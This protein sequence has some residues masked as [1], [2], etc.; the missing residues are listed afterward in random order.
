M[1][2][3]T[4]MNDIRIG[5]GYDF[6]KLIEGDS[7][8]LAGVEIKCK[9]EIS[10]HSDGDIVLHALSDSIYGAIANGDI[11]VHF[12]SNDQNLDISS[13]HILAHACETLVTSGYYIGN[14]D[15][16]I[17]LEEPRIQDIVPEMRKNISNLTSLNMEYISIKSSTSQGVGLIGNNQA[18]ACYSSI[19]IKK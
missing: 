5:Y 19:L 17:L 1:I 11:G 13:K 7:I 15:I 14:I 16:T 18:I 2:Q 4:A 6:H 8:T 12:P 3:K 9:Y 10:A